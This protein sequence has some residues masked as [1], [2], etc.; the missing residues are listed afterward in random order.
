[1]CSVESDGT[2][3]QHLSGVGF[4]NGL[5]FG[6]DETAFYYTDSDRKVIVQHGYDSVHSVIGECVGRAARDRFP[7]A[8]IA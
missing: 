6:L 7:S 4:P 3:A 2:V 8:E 5:A 1:M